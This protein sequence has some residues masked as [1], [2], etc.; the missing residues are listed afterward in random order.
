[1]HTDINQIIN[2]KRTIAV[3]ERRKALQQFMRDLARIDQVRNSKPF[4]DFIRLDE[5]VETETLDQNNSGN[6]YYGGSS[7]YRTES[8]RMVESPDIPMGNSGAKKDSAARGSR[9][10]FK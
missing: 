7:I 1:V 5:N 10:K 6:A 9:S 8:K 2:S 3:E 4:R